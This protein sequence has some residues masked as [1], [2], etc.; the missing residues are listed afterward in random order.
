M[1]S[2]QQAS[3]GVSAL[4]SAPRDSSSATSV[5]SSPIS[6]SRHSN[7][8]R[9]ISDIQN[10]SPAPQARALGLPSIPGDQPIPHQVLFPAPKHRG[11][12]GPFRPLYH[13]MTDLS[14]RWGAPSYLSLHPPW[15][16]GFLVQSLAGPPQLQKG[17]SGSGPTAPSQRRPPVGRGREK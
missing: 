5:P 17:P 10:G 16:L 6:N 13:H 3:P 4:P 8:R 15:L 7:Q 12:L 11:K 2:S 1:K 14:V 9:P